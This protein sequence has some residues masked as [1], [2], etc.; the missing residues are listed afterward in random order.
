[1]RH[2]GVERGL[3]ARALARDARRLGLLPFLP[4]GVLRRRVA[5][6]QRRTER[7]V[8]LLHQPEYLGRTRVA[9]LDRLHPAEDGAPHALRGA[10]MGDDRTIAAPR[11]L[12]DRLDLVEG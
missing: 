7:D 9:V 1:D 3:E 8:V 11:G 10:R 6:R 5:G 4:A 12:R 2:A